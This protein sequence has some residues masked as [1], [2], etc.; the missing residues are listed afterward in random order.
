MLE[1]PEER[2]ELLRKGFSG[3]EIE[4]LYNKLNNIKIVSTPISFEI[5]EFDHPQNRKGSTTA[6]VV[7]AC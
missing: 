5:V 3:K 1:I 2:I 6:A 4:M 7:E